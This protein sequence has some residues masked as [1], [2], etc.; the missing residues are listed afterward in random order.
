MGVPSYIMMMLLPQLNAFD[1]V[2]R[3]STLFGEGYFERLG[4]IV[5]SFGFRRILIVSDPG[6][7]RAGFVA[8][9]VKMLW[10]KKMEV[11]AFHDF[12]A[13]P[14]TE[15]IRKCHNFAWPLMIDCIIGLGGGSSM[16]VAKA[17]NYLLTNGGEMKDYV[18][19]GKTTR[20]M[21]PMIGIPTTA[22]TGSEAQS[23][24]IISDARTHI[25]MAIGDPQA[26]F[27]V[28]ILDPTL[29]VSQPPEVTAASGYDALAHAVESFVTTKRT[30]WS[31][32]LAREAFQLLDA[33][34]ETVLRSPGDLR[35]RGA[36][37]LGAH[38][39]GMAIEG[40]MLGATH[41]CANP[42]TAH[43]GIV[44]GV[45]LS[46]LLPHIIRWNA[47]FADYTDLR[48][49]LASRMADLAE[50]AGMPASLR[51]AG[52]QSTMFDI[53]SQE[54]GQQWTGK[55]NPRPFDAAGAMEIYQCAY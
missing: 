20:P 8:R 35:A 33:N 14:D 16:D 47:G 6:V 36:M 9:A 53:L 39:A 23:Y 32:M 46:M 10:D 40:S 52:V 5:E 17:V 25:K 22:G 3:T 48:E 49:D 31:M 42:L 4:Q 44:H 2:P 28:T 50:A 38:W 1:Y 51:S 15:M 29:T 30:P 37:L 18:G 24:C 34:F 55:H 7:E 19:Y 43:Y 41:A 12:G 11:W 26:A 21:Y 27:R 13:N 45:A 54:A